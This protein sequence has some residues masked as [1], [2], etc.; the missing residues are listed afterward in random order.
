MKKNEFVVSAIGEIE[1]QN[2]IMIHAAQWHDAEDSKESALHNEAFFNYTH[3]L[4]SIRKRFKSLLRRSKVTQLESDL[5][6]MFLDN[7]TRML[8]KQYGWKIESYIQS[9]DGSSVKVN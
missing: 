9:P 7:N 6:N 4:Q 1:S 8:V 5:V 2:H 3:T